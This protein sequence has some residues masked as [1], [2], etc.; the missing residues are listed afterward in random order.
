MNIT[1]NV[2][3]DSDVYINDIFYCSITYDYKN[4]WTKIELPVDNTVVKISNKY[5]S[6]DSYFLHKSDDEHIC[7]ENELS[8]EYVNIGT[9]IYVS[10][11]KLAVA[12]LGKIFTNAEFEIYNDIVIVSKDFRYGAILIDGNEILPMEYSYVAYKDGF[13]AVYKDGACGIVSKDGNVLFPLSTDR[14]VDYVGQGFF[15]ARN[16]PFLFNAKRSQISYMKRNYNKIYRFHEGLAIVSSSDVFEKWGFIDEKGDEIISPKYDEVRNFCE[17]F[18][19]ICLDGKWGFVDRNGQEIVAPEYMEV[20]DFDRGLSVVRNWNRKWGIIDSTGKVFM[21]CVASNEPCFD[22]N[23]FANI[24]ITESSWNSV[25]ISIEGFQMIYNHSSTGESREI[26]LPLEFGL[27]IKCENDIGITYDGEKYGYIS[28]D[29]KRI[30]ENKFDCV[31]AFQFYEGKG[32]ARV[33]YKSETGIIDDSGAVCVMDG[34]ER[35][36]L[37]IKYDW[38]YDFSEG[39]SRVISKGEVRF[40]NRQYEEV[41]NLK[42]LYS[43][44]GDFHNSLAKVKKHEDDEE[45]ICK[46]GFIDKK[47]NVAIPVV[48][49]DVYDFENIVSPFRI[50]SE[51]DYIFD[52][53]PILGY[54]GG[55][56]G[57]IGT[58]GQVVLNPKY[59]KINKM[60]DN[61]ATFITNLKYLETNNYGRWNVGKYGIIDSQGNEIVKA[62]YDMIF[63]YKNQFAKANIGGKWQ[64]TK[65]GLAFVGGKYTLLDLRGQELCELK[66]DWMDFP[67]DGMARVNIGGYWN[68]DYTE[69]IGGKWGYINIQGEEIIKPKYTSA[70][71][72][73]DGTAEVENV[74]FNGRGNGSWNTIDKEGRMEVSH[75]SNDES[76]IWISNQYDWG[77]LCSNGLIAVAKDDKCGFINRDGIIVVPLIYDDVYDFINGTAKVRKVCQEG[78]IDENGNIVKAFSEI[79]FHNQC[80][81]DNDDDDYGSVHYGR[82]KGSYAQDV[83]GYSDDDIDSIF[84]GEPDAYWNID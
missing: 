2:N 62:K 33:Q 6:A 81:E 54:V 61:R 46:V 9:P 40:I 45:F 51:V 53:C 7:I 27:I 38:G 32:Y 70:N 18:A 24:Y 5:F 80:N 84:D 48:Y 30:T 79:E 52:D 26:K 19:A 74:S 31:G 59:D 76:K 10:M 41:I 64:E 47:G 35:V 50:N 78:E 82:Y 28:I 15:L 57:L 17:G 20:K 25:K 1:L 14:S 3:A 8:K 21:S 66:Y 22:S 73:C 11:D 55:K 39:L 58:S 42:K 63:G 67:C 12:R 13:L 56:W 75:Y 4:R 43:E 16:Q 29:G 65:S 71:N 37:P 49:D 44:V 72:F 23:G 83:E 34:K 77:W 60:I 68:E 69:F 36:S